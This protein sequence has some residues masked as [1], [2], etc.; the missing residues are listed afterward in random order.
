MSML[1]NDLEVK[2]KEMMGLSC[3]GL[4]IARVRFLPIL[5]GGIIP[6]AEALLEIL[7]ELRVVFA[8]LPIGT[9]C[10]VHHSSQQ[11]EEELLEFVST[12]LRSS[13]FCEAGAE[14]GTHWPAAVVALVEHRSH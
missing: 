9:V 5:R 2:R 7:H 3:C 13:L 14:T 6:C 1:K 10:V 4:A 8:R 11:V 12:L